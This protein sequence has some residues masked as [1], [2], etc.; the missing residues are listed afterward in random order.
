MLDIYKSC[1]VSSALAAEREDMAVVRKIT[2]MAL[3]VSLYSCGGADSIGTDLTSSAPNNGLSG[4][5]AGLFAHDSGRP[6]TNYWML[7][8]ASLSTGNFTQITKAGWADPNQFE[9]GSD[10]DIEPKRLG[11]PGYVFTDHDCKIENLSFFGCVALLDQNGQRESG[12]ITKGKIRGN[13]KLSPDGR[14]IALILQDDVSGNGVLEL[15]TTTGDL[16][17]RTFTGVSI[18]AGAEVEWHPDGRI[19][20][21]QNAS[22]RTIYITDKYETSFGTT[23]TLPESYPGFIRDL[24]ISPNGN[25][26]AFSVIKETDSATLGLSIGETLVI[27]LMTKQIRKLLNDVQA[28]QHNE[29]KSSVLGPRWSPDGRWILVRYES[30]YSDSSTVDTGTTG[31]RSYLIAIPSDGVEV[32]LFPADDK[33][34]TA[35][36]KIVTNV[37]ELGAWIDPELSDRWLGESYFWINQ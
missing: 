24:A 21:L 25:S 32:P 14:F 31:G 7:W 11:R 30:S 5:I 26:L 12:F 27:D 4:T 19:F 33:F 20:F 13:A 15:Y 3:I 10:F 18:A 23:L 6:S 16:V 34:E 22:T 28:M 17:S 36:V 35:A 37:L 2:V 1:D 9:A 29:G 8:S